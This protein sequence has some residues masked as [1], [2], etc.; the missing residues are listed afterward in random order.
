MAKAEQSGLEV[1]T[2]ALFSK[3]GFSNE[4]L[5]HQDEKLLLFDLND[6]KQLF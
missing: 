4:L 2:Y 3:S 1:D 6:L 5:Q